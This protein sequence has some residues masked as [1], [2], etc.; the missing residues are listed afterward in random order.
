[1]RHPAFLAA[2]AVTLAHLAVSP[3][4]A[5]TIYDLVDYS[6]AG[7]QNGVVLSG[8]ITTDGTIG[9][10]NDASHIESWTLTFTSGGTSRT[11]SSTDFIALATVNNVMVDEASIHL[12]PESSGLSFYMTRSDGAVDSV[13][14]FPNQYANITATPVNLFWS[15]STDQFAGSGGLSIAQSTPEPTSLT[16]MLAGAG[17]LAGAGFVRRRRQ[18]AP[19]QRVSLPTPS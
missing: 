2:I 16:L 17:G 19:S 12:G 8:S 5:G 7:L 18:T 11:F 1:M 13:G 10:Y 3:A 4:T 14:W 6:G 9:V 15:T